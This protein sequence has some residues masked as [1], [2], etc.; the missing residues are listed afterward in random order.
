MALIP[1][2]RLPDP[3]AANGC[4]RLS[5]SDKRVQQRLAITS[6]AGETSSF[7]VPRTSVYPNS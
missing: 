3:A 4:D 7:A 6:V 1:I 5:S 2:R